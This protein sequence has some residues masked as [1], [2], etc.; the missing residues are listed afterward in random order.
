MICENFSYF[1]LQNKK[2]GWLL[3]ITVV[4][5]VTITAIASQYNLGSVLTIHFAKS[6][7]NHIKSQQMPGDTQQQQT[8]IGKWIPELYTRIMTFQPHF[9]IQS[10]PISTLLNLGESEFKLSSIH[11]RGSGGFE[12]YDW[13]SWILRHLV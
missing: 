8:D 3:D 9:F 1:Y 10:L 6:S 4:F 5:T 12:K 7:S 13:K 2:L 11:R